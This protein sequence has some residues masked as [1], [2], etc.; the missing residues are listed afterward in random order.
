MGDVHPAAIK[1]ELARKIAEKTPG[2]LGHCLFGSD[3]ADAVEA[4]LKTA[5][6]YTGKPGVLA[7]TGGYH[8][9]TYGALAVTSRADFRDPFLGQLPRFARHVPYAEPRA[10]PAGCNERCPQNCLG[11]VREALQD[12][13]IGAVIMEPIQGRGGI[14]EPPPGWL[15]GLRHLCDEHGVLLIAD[16]IFT[17]WGRTGDWFACDAESVIPDILCAGKALGGGFPISACV[18]QPHVMA[19]WG[20]S[21]GE[22]L[23]TSTF[24][25]S[26]LGCAAALAAIAELEE[27]DLP[28][29]AR[30]V[31]AYFKE[32]LRE[33]AAR[34]PDAVAEVRGRGLM[35]GIRL[36]SAALA[37]RLVY[38]LL[39][40]GIIVLPAGPGDVLELVPPLTIA[41]EQIDWA[42]GEMDAA[43]RLA[44][45]GR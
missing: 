1:V 22:A 42:L 44:I 29:R 45:Q 21:R 30:A 9:L 17:G 6:L 27:R 37:L 41:R 20:E 11:F 31:G 34:R 5:C 10:C 3:G 8:G 12:E 26:P 38:D 33:L 18:A 14:V 7:F 15:R 16:E 28:G 25:G 23:H 35:L 13:S 19:A 32:R 24:L 36:S 39:A 2:D 40:R 4:A 43:L